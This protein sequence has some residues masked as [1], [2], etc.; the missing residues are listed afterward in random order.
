MA[1]NVLYVAIV[2]YDLRVSVTRTLKSQ[3]TLCSTYSYRTRDIYLGATVGAAT[4]VINHR[5]Q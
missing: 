4:E 2:Q 3:N 1:D 5:I